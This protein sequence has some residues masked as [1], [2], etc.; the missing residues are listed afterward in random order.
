LQPTSAEPISYD[1]TKRC[2]AITT[3]TSPLMPEEFHE[4]ISYGMAMKF[5]AIQLTDK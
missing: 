4:I 1:Y 2:A 3:S 5:D